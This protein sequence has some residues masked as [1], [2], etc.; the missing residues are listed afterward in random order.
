M[1]KKTK[2]IM[3]TDPID[4]DK[5][6]KEVNI[7]VPKDYKSMKAKKYTKKNTKKELTWME[8]IKNFLQK[9]TLR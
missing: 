3:L 2:K 6:S 5:F 4:V 8:K 9:L 7:I 1:A